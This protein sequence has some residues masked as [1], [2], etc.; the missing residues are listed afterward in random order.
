MS[1]TRFVLVSEARTGS[2]LLMYAIADHPEVICYGECF[3]E[4]SNEHFRTHIDGS[5]HAWHRVRGGIH[6]ELLPE[7]DIDIPARTVL[8]EYIYRSDYPAGKRAVGFK[9]Q[10]FQGRPASPWSTTRGLLQELADLRII[11]LH[12][13]NLLEQIASARLAQATK[14]WIVSHESD[15]PVDPP[16]IHLPVSRVE[17]FFADQS[18]NLKL[19]AEHFRSHRYLRL[20]YE[21]LVSDFAQRYEEV[22]QFLSLTIHAPPPPRTI[23]Q[24]RQR[25]PDA[26]ENYGELK[27]AFVNTPWAG[28]FRE[29]DSQAVC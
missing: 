25:M 5:P 23:K 19:I 29:D 9:Y 22:Q 4:H 28:F 21:D 20:S 3:R 1:L 18:R 24:S 14:Q 27:A 13:Q 17:A 15:L 2:N 7:F 11:H 26:I 12:R 16:K 8:E 10:W 6:H